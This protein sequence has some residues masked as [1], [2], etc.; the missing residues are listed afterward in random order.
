MR[1][2]ARRE[3]RLYQW[4]ASYRP[5]LLIRLN[6]DADTAH[7]RKPDHKLAS[8]RIKTAVFPKIEFR[9]AKILEI[10]SCEPYPQVLEAALAAAQTVLL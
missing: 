10:D 2:L 4:M 9:G 5:A 1:A 6:I 3:Q 8:L 7:A